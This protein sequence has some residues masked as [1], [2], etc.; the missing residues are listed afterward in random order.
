LLEAAGAEP[1]GRKACAQWTARLV[2]QLEAGV[3]A[4]II[5]GVLESCG[6]ECQSRARVKKARA[7]WRDSG[8]DVRACLDRWCR[9]GLVF[10]AELDG[11]VIRFYY[12]RCFC[13]RVNAASNLSRTYCHCSRGWVRELF[14]Q[15]FEVEAD[16][17]L[18]RS[19]QAGDEGC[20]FEVRLALD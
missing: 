5:A 20:E 4:A 14:E 17:K 15:V 10:R 7:I 2:E 8:G 3:D 13:G 19:V 18:V 12:P 6:R 11:D 1:T 16:V 9:E